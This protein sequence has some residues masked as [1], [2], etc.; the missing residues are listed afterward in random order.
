M[1]FLYDV[2]DIL[3]KFRDWDNEN[4]KKLLFGRELFFSSYRLF[5]DP[6]DGGIPFQYDPNEL[7][8]ENIFRKMLESARKTHPK[9]NE[10]ALH[11]IAFEQQQKGRFQDNAYMA[12]FQNDVA[13]DLARDFGIV[14]L[15]KSPINFLLWSYYAQSHKG[16]A[17]GFK[18]VE[19]FEDT[20]ASFA[21][22]QYQDDLPML[23]LFEDSVTA[24]TKLLGTKSSTWK[25]EEEYRLTKIGYSNRIVTLRPK[26]IADIT[27][28]CKMEHK[29]KLT[30]VDY[31]KENLPHATVHEMVQSKTKFELTRMR[32]F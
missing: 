25:H 1:K 18:K 6:F 26:T 9:I 32:I 12:K 30:I 17:M 14:C 11:Q 23:G 10:E 31:V 3:Y 22:M 15:C 20:Q 13:D 2:P 19:L 27:C 7:T 29:N 8:E 4:S 28:G 24:I 16:F 21:H 5:N